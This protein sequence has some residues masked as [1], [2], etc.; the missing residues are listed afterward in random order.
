MSTVSNA[1]E[2]GWDQ[3]FDPLRRRREFGDLFASA[4]SGEALMPVLA[5]TKGSR[6][7]DA[8]AWSRF[9]TGDERGNT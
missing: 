7:Q 2:D 1:S 6:L 5:A 8:L 4:G 3:W 9:L